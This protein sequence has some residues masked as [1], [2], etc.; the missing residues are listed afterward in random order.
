MSQR[1]DRKET[2]A[3]WQEA[4][5]SGA[6]KRWE[7]ERALFDRRLSGEDGASCGRAIRH[8]L[9]LL[10]EVGILAPGHAQRVKELDF[11]ELSGSDQMR[12]RSTRHQRDY[13]VLGLTGRPSEQPLIERALQLNDGRRLV[14]GSLS[15]QVIV[16]EN[17]ARVA[18]MNI[19]LRGFD[20]RRGRKTFQRYDLDFAQMGDGPV[21]HF[22]AHWHVGDDPDES[23][24]EEDPRLPAV[25]LHPTEVIEMF[26]ET[27]FPRGPDDVA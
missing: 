17:L 22:N 8:H 4:S 15:L 25:V 13:V 23:L 1:R 21:T 5:F 14:G 9:A 11:D 18:A 3:R 2:W 12:L 7:A 27:W 10:Q 16:D 6:K 24:A 19:Q 20:R 26:V